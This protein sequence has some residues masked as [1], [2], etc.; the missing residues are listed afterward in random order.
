MR[1]VTEK[2][3]EPQKNAHRQ[4][5]RNMCRYQDSFP[6]RCESTIVIKRS[7]TWSH[8]DALIRVSKARVGDL[9]W[10]PSSGITGVFRRQLA[11]SP[12]HLL[13]EATL[14]YKAFQL[15]RILRLSRVGDLGSGFGLALQLGS[16]FRMLHSVFGLG[17][18]LGKCIRGPLRKCTGVKPSRVEFAFT[19]MRGR[20]S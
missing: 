13:S 10:T 16:C 12:V 4:E 11:V 6:G 7:F 2:S 3:R 18:F 1:K 5:K 19:S 8:S 9:G 15:V 17:L 20:V 14:S